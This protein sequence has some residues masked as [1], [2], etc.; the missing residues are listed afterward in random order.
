[1]RRAPPWRGSGGFDP[2]TPAEGD[3]AGREDGAT[4]PGLEGA[5][6]V[7]VTVI[8]QGRVN[9]R[10]VPISKAEF[11]EH[12][13]GPGVGLRVGPGRDVCGTRARV[14]PAGDAGLVDVDGGDVSG[15]LAAARTPQAGRGSTEA[16]GRLSS[17]ARCCL[18][19]S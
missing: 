11:Q 16:R 8:E 9:T 12:V 5:V 13:A 17:C 15:P 1:M 19:P 14:E 10:P 7:D 18:H 3:T 2:W 4:E 6:V